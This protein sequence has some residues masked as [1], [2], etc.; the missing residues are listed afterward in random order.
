MIDPR[1]KKYLFDIL[2]A[3]NQIEQF[4]EGNHDFTEYQQNAMLRSAT[5]RQLI[6]VGE[7]VNRLRQMDKNIPL[8]ASHSIVQFRNRITHEYD[9]ID[10]ENVWAILV[11]HLPK[12]KQE[13]E[14]LLLE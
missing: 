4:L 2:T 3:I 5:E 13:V 10:D 6:I 7:A 11:K 8:T 14:Q 12:L 1:A 9:R